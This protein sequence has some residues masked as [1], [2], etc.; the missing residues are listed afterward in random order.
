MVNGIGGNQGKCT[1]KGGVGGWKQNGQLPGNVEFAYTQGKGNK[2]GIRKMAEKLGVDLDN[3]IDGVELS[4]Q[5]QEALEVNKPETQDK[6]E[7]LKEMEQ[8]NQQNT[9]E[10]L[11]QKILDFFTKLLGTVET[12]QNETAEQETP[13]A[14][15]PEAD[16]DA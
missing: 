11:L 5:A 14:D 10:G 9:P 15:K 13:E 12:P 16:K 8:N 2:T 4:P 3:K 1:D 7:P 6:E